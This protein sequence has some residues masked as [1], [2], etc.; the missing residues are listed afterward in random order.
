MLVSFVG[1]AGIYACTCVDKSSSSTTKIKSHVRDKTESGVDCIAS[2]GYRPRG[3]VWQNAAR[4]ASES[5]RAVVVGNG[6]GGR[7]GRGRRSARVL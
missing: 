2:V 3:A 5:A 7:P 4:A 1:D 6:I